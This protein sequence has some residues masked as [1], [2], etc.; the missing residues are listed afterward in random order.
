MLIDANGNINVK[1]SVS[2]DTYKCIVQDAGLMFIL[3]NNW[4]PVDLGNKKRKGYDSLDGDDKYM[5]RTK[6]RNK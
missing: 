3:Q 1:N 2:I 5:V 4:T 6:K